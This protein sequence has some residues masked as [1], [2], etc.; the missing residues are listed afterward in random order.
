ME[1]PKPEITIKL[2]VPN[3]ALDQIEHPPT[4]EFPIQKES[5]VPEPQ[6]LPMVPKQPKPM[7]LEQT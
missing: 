7:V 2:Q 4:P 1:P 3:E 6:Q 5:E